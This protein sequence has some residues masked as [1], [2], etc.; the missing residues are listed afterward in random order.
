MGKLY[1]GFVLIAIILFSG[2]VAQKEDNH[3]AEETIVDSV[4]ERFLASRNPDFRTGLNADIPEMNFSNAEYFR[5]PIILENE[6]ILEI[7]NSHCLIGNDVKLS[8]NAM[9][10]VR[11]SL[12]DF[13]NSFA[14]QYG[15][16]SEGNA[17][18]IL[19]NSVV[20]S[21]FPMNFEFRGNSKLEMK[22]VKKTGKD[23]T[24]PW[25]TF[26][27]VSGAYVRNS[28]FDATLWD[29]AELNIENS[30]SVYIEIVFPTGS[31]SDALFDVNL[32]NFSF[33]GENERGIGYK[34]RIKNS[35]ARGW[36]FTINPQ[37]NITIRNAHNV[38][39]T[40]VAKEPWKNET[41]FLDN[42]KEKYYENASWN[43]G[44]TK[45]RFLEV[46]AWQWSPLAYESNIVIVNNSH[47]AD[48]AWGGGSGKIF[49]NNSEVFFIRARENME[50]TAG[51]SLIHG[52]VI[53]TDKSRIFLY[54]VTVEGKTV[55]DGG[56][57]SRNDI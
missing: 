50:I 51:N 3:T 7:T 33:P 23:I 4:P 49:I 56:T 52:D 24:F 15:V 9:L 53:A 26:G 37:S 6:D 30:P 29:M 8:G 47:L 45:L 54:N 2:C 22:N 21:S 41:I 18:I 46:D 1:F 57:I 19:E 17:R 10:I 28:K 35:T 5:E 48:I 44:D 27:D 13:N 34:I 39:M 25:M 43:F 14:Y 40:M 12:L 31:A 20:K 36:G 38:V 55:E 32:Q 16:Y 42:L 11:D